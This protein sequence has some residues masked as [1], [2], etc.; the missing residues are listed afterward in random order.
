MS[1]H[2]ASGSDNY[3][4]FEKKGLHFIHLNT[5]SL[6][7]KLDEVRILA[8][9]TSAACICTTETWLDETIDDREIHIDNYT[10]RRNDKNRHGGGVCM[11]IRRDLAF[12]SVDELCHDDIEATW[13]ELLLPKTKPILC[14]VL[15]RPLDQSDFYDVFEGFCLDS[16]LL[17]ERECI[18][19]GDFNTNVSGTKTCTLVKS[20][21][22]LS[23]LLNWTQ[24]IEDPTRV[25]TTTSSTIDLVFCL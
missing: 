2:N 17:N 11:Y 13:I 24:I 1:S 20:L 23:D 15:Y 9:N 21:K 12:N 22:A 5:R 18:V 7:S 6:L 4:C 10:V 8:R 25:T 16:A 19:L 14:G 3:K